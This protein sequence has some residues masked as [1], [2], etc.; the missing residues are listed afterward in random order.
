MSIIIRNETTFEVTLIFDR[1]S[2]QQQELIILPNKSVEVPLKVFT[3]CYLDTLS[4]KISNGV[5]KIKNYRR[6]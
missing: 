5:I 4:I 6:E 1:D 3:R 2:E